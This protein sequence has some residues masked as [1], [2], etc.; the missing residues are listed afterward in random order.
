M[1]CLHCLKPCPEHSVTY[2]LTCHKH[3]GECKIGDCTRTVTRTFAIHLNGKVVEVFGV[4]ERPMC[5]LLAKYRGAFEV[6]TEFAD[7]L[8][9]R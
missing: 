4:C 3:D 2:C 9:L 8:Q 1:Q 6:G 5:A 7:V